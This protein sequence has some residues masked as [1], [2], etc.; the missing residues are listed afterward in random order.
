MPKLFKALLTSLFSKKQFLLQERALLCLLVHFPVQEVQAVF[1][2]S[3]S[4]FEP[5]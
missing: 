4:N 3:Q 1:Y 5:K 2:P